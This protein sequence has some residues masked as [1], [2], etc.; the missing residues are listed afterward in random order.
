[1]FLSGQLC[2]V[3][4]DGLSGG[5]GGVVGGIQRGILNGSLDSILD[6][7]FASGLE[8]RLVFSFS[9]ERR[10]TFVSDQV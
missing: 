7:E 3:T 6:G 1:L 4:G 9:D 2:G 8:L 5:L 10:H